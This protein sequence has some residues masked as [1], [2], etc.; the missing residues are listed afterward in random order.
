M[1]SLLEFLGL[2]DAGDSYADRGVL[3]A[4]NRA[5]TPLLQK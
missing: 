1:S 2:D 3:D 5:L 4:K